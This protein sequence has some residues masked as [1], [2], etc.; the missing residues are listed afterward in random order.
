MLAGAVDL[1]IVDGRDVEAVT[2]PPGRFLDQA[3]QARGN[4]VAMP[5]AVFGEA[6]H[7][8]PIIGAFDGEDALGDGMLLDVE[9]QRGDPLGESEMSRGGEGP[10]EG[11]EQGLPDRPEERSVSHRGVSWWSLMGG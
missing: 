5:G 2:G 4:I 6:L 1:G 9:C 11:S 10:G 7:G 8:L 3:G